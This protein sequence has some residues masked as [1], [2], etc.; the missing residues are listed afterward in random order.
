MSDENKLAENKLIILYLLKKTGEPLSNDNIYQ[1]VMERSIM[2]FI[3]VQQYLGDL[4][5]SSFIQAFEEN[6][7][8]KYTLTPSGEKA[9]LI[10]ENNISSW[11]RVAAG[12]YISN[13]HKIKNEDKITATYTLQENGEY[14]VK[15]A[16]GESGSTMLQI[17]TSVPTKEQAI[18]ICTNWK[19]NTSRIISSLFTSLTKKYN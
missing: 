5:D 15:C 2:D 18:L 3:S 19:E 4:T 12:E 14:L 7:T 13:R 11:L 17:N 9:V 10:F 8:T 1:F 16:A 6:G